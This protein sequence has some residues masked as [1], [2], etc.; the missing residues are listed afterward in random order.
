MDAVVHRIAGFAARFPDKPALKGERETVTYHSLLTRA[1]RLAAWLRQCEFGRAVL[2]RE[3]GVEWIVIDLACA[4]AG[5]T[6]IPAPTF[7]SDRQIAH[8][9]RR[10]QPDVVFIEDAVRARRLGLV[11][12]QDTFVLENTHAVIMSTPERNH[13]TNGSFF[14]KITFTSGTTGKPKGVC[15]TSDAIEKV[16]LSLL[17]AL[18]QLPVQRHMTLLPLST[19]LEN[20]AG[21]YVPL[22]MGSCVHVFSGES[23]G[24]SG[25]SGLQPAVLLARI[26]DVA[27]DSLILIP[28]MLNVL[29]DAAD[30]GLLDAPQPR[31]IAVGGGKVSPSRLR[32]ARELGLPVYEGYGLSECAS[33]VS[34]NTPAADRPGSAGKPLSHVRVRVDDGRVL[35]NTGFG[36]NYIDAD[37]S[38]PPH[39]SLHNETGTWIDTGDL[40]HLDEDGFLHINGRAKNILINSYGRNISPE[41]V[42]SE[43]L[44]SSELRQCAVFGDDKPFCAAVVVADSSQTDIG[45]IIE[46]INR[47]LPDYARIQGW[48]AADEPFSVGNGL[49]TANGRP[50]R[51]AI[52]RRYRR[53]L[54][55]IYGISQPSPKGIDM[56]DFYPQLLQRTEQNRHY[57][58]SS[59]IIDRTL[60][61]GL[62]R[63]EYLAFLT[64]AYYHVRHTVPLLMA[65]GSRLPQHQEWLRVAVGEYIEEETGHQ[66]WI[67]NDIAACGGDKEKVRHGTPLPA[68]E[69]MV[70][71]AYDTVQRHNPV[72][73]FGMVLVLEGTSI[74]LASRAADCIQ[75]SLGLPDRA[76]SYLRSHGS[77]DQEH[78]RFF[79]KLMNR[80]KDTGDREAVVHRANMFYRLYADIFRSLDV[81]TAKAA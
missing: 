22:M 60:R 47:E 25:S 17:H 14:A 32:K 3:N 15:L 75:Q 78:I 48:I 20:I 11:V 76:F 65:A 57:L 12:A 9:I 5:V 34:L 49:L 28:Q 26:N 16:A 71:Y 37:N 13:D 44:Q 10:S 79:E 27:P 58:L 55:A 6:L 72:G 42:E 50:R 38:A 63:S 64:E 51:E 77:L 62:T 52:E 36:V 24:L 54:D 2:Y 46:R 21:V 4:I 35:V 8:L 80:L 31:F 67:L 39:S 33:V 41:W 1:Q 29:V 56:N 81:Q 19:L 53:Q 7:F 66:E 59:P 40:G 73:F 70:A 23:L 61:G 18:E 43:L 74:A 68:T 45:S 69:L 30:A